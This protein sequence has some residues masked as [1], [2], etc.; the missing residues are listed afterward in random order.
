MAIERKDESKQK[1]VKKNPN[2]IDNKLDPCNKPH[3]AEATRNTD[4]DEACDDAV[5]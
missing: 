1:S 2:E 3:V 4:A 5:H